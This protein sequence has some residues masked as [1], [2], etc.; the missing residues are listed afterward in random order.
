MKALTQIQTIQN[1]A[2]TDAF[3]ALGEVPD[4]AQGKIDYLARLRDQ[5]DVQSSLI[6]EEIK[7]LQTKKRQIEKAN[8][9]LDLFIKQEMSDEG[10]IGMEGLEF[11]FSL[12][13]SQGSLI[14]DDESLIPES[15]FI[16]ETTRKPNT[17][18]IKAML[19][20]GQV[21]E[22]CSLV[23]GKRLTIKLKGE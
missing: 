15:L 20:S 9:D 21:V 8:D 10:M 16:V 3:Y 13:N 5:L 11:K 2:I 4:N 22:G 18:L 19:E 17:K 14:I 6:S 23:S 12:A 7:K 1:N